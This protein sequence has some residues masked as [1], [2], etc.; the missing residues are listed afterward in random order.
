MIPEGAFVL[1][2]EATPAPLRA[3]A[4]TA[5]TYETWRLGLPAREGFVVTRWS[6]GIASW[7]GEAI[8]QK[9]WKKVL[10]R[11]DSSEERGSYMRG[12]FQIE[13]REVD[14]RVPEILAMGRIV[15]LL[16]PSDRHENL[17]GINLLLPNGKAE[18][19]LEIVGPGFDVSDINRGD[20]T[21][22]ERIRLLCY[23]D[24]VLP[25]VL[26]RHLV[27]PEDYAISKRLRLEKIGRSL[28]TGAPLSPGD[29]AGAGEE[30]LRKID[31]TLLLDQEAYAP[32]P[33]SLLRRYV[34]L[35]RD[36]PWRLGWG[37]QERE[38]VVSAS[39]LPGGSEPR[40]V[41]WDI[42]RPSTKYVLPI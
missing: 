33:E 12:G 32:L 3:Y 4:K 23:A 11:T 31:R 34:D 26:S 15:S 7:L 18:A 24:R 37:S 6:E 21:P 27:T 16:E 20:V 14:A 13:A 39:V 42:V 9:G 1:G 2:A 40:M 30:H 38:F 5:S 17:Y 41:F 19:I 35:V 28:T 8:R 25:A 36:L 10:V 22:H 29:L